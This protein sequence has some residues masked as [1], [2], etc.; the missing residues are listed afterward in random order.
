MMS[1]FESATRR[2]DCRRHFAKPASFR[3]SPARPAAP[4]GLSA[5]GPLREG[6]AIGVSLVG[7]D[8]EMG[9]TGTVTHIDGTRV[10]AFGHPFYGLGPTEFPL[11][12]AYVYTI[13][14]SLMTSFKISTLGEMIGTMQQDRA[15][16]IAGTLGKGPRLI[17]MKVTLER[18]A[19]RLTPHAELSARR[20]ISCS[21]RSLPT[22]R[23]STRWAHTNGSSAPPPSACRAARTSR[24]WRPRRGRCV[25]RRQPDAGSFDG[26]GWPAHDAPVERRRARDDRWPRITVTTGETAQRHDRARLARRGPAPRRPHHSPEGADAQLSWRRKDLDRADR[27]PGQRYRRSVHSRD[28]RP[29]AELDGTA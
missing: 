17:P 14:P 19:R 29:S 22:S 26:R 10:Y 4:T 2:S 28:R 27:D 3:S 24:A 9:A 23:C 18:G 20:T 1:G 16:A 15:T 6:D 8:L 21:R 11:T 13:L 5:T 7:G 12:R 25:H